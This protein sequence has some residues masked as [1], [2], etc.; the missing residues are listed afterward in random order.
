M[1][2]EGQGPILC[3]S[4][5]CRRVDEIDSHTLWL[6]ER[7]TSGVGDGLVLNI[8]SG[9]PISLTRAQVQ[10]FSSSLCHTVPLIAV[11]SGRQGHLHLCLASRHA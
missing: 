8:R 9:A 6:V 3:T 7:A 4:S 5:I 10:I 2:S 1:H 11:H